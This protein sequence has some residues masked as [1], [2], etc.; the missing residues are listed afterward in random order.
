[1]RSGNQRDGPLHYWL[2]IG[3]RRG[4][5]GW[6]FHVRRSGQGWHYQRRRTAFDNSFTYYSHA[7]VGTSPLSPS[8]V[9]TLET[10]LA[11]VAIDPQGGAQFGYWDCRDWLMDAYTQLQSM[12]L[13]RGDLSW[14]HVMRCVDMGV[15]DVTGN[16][17][18]GS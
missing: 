5:S 3:D 10:L 2:W 8:E 14:E 15:N 7:V 18:G 12:E 1:V 6:K 17:R 16:L 13:I 9:A 11:E 4:R